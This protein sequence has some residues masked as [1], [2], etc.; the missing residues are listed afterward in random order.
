MRRASA[1]ALLLALACGGPAAAAD[2][3]EDP[4]AARTTAQ[5][6]SPPAFD[7]TRLIEVLQPAGST[8]SHG[9]DP[10]TLAVGPDG[11]VR[12]VL[13]AWRPGGASNVL[14]EGIRCASGEYRVHARHSDE[15]GWTLAPADSPWRALTSG[16]GARVAWIIARMGAC[17][18][19]VP[20]GSAEDIARRLRTGKLPGYE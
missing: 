4:G 15:R 20:G 6:V 5:P 16:A 14:Y 12:F 18:G 10:G 17:E 3:D 7:R 9:V 13:V 19:H 1:L 2:D 11:E 8:L